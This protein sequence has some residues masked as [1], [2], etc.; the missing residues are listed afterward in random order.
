MNYKVRCVS[1]F[2]DGNC[3]PKEAKPGDEFIVSDNE[4]AH[5]MQSAKDSWDV[6]ERQLPM[7]PEAIKEVE[8]VLKSASKAKPNAKKN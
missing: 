3:N 8:K 1:E 5:L 2:R 7:P 4:Y 6:I